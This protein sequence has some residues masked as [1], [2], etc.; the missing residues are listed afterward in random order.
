VQQQQQQTNVA[1]LIDQISA[2]K[3]ADL[4]ALLANL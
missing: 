3:L 1:P 4:A 2:Q